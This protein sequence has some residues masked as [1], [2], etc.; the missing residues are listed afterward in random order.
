M[1]PVAAADA[2]DGLILHIKVEFAPGS[3]GE[4]YAPG[5]VGMGLVERNGRW[6]R[7]IEAIGG[8]GHS[9][10]ADFTAALVIVEQVNR[11]VFGNGR[12]RFRRHLHAHAGI[13][14]ENQ[15]GG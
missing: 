1:N 15:V 5:V 7:E 2:N 12:I 6:R 14:D 4:L 9:P 8:F 11:A 13:G 10:L 3:V